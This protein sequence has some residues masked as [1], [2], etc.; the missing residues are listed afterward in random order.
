M[1]AERWELNSIPLRQLAVAVLSKDPHC[2]PP[3]EEEPRKGGP[4]IACS[5]FPG[6]PFVVASWNVCTLSD[7]WLGARR[8]TALIACELARYDIYIAAL[9]ETRLPDEGSLVEMGTGYTFFW[10]GQPKDAFHIHDVVLAAR[11]ALL[12]STHESPIA[13]EERFITLRLPLAKNRFATFVSVYA[14]TLDTSDDVKARFYDT[15]YS[16][17]RRILRN[18]KIILLGEFNARAGRNNNIWK[19]VIDHHGVGN[20]NS[21][22]LRLLF[23]PTFSICGNQPKNSENFTY[24]GSNL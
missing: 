10:S 18:D 17:L 7:T 23:A 1:V 14:P 13:I 9:S 24:L 16:T 8:S 6:R 19:G 4:N 20:M 15:L 11:T 2:S 12:Q 3:V 5:T 22:C 21:S